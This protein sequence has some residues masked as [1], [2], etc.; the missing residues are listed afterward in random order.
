ME[1]EW[2]DS[3]LSNRVNSKLLPSLSYPE[4]QNGLN[5][6]LLFSNRFNQKEVIKLIE[7]EI[8][9]IK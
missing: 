3:T 7:E 2:I 8:D 5:K 9:R 1:G 4:F 6:K